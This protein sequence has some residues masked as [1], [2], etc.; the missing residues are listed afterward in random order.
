MFNLE[1]G[2][3]QIFET[4]L[5][6]SD[7]SNLAS[8]FKAVSDETRLRILMTLLL[9]RELCVCDLASILSLTKSA[10]SHQLSQ[11]KLKKL[12]TCRRDGA[13][14]YYSLSDKH[15]E[16]VLKIAFEHIKE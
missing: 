5:D 7:I 8:F 1:V 13:Y 4:E 16:K 6:D 9:S 14:M 2:M 10:V 15:V 11:L 3:K 12:I